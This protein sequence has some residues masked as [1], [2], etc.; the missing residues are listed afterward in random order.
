MFT[1]LEPH[2]G[3][4]LPD[5]QLQYFV[6]SSV[7]MNPSQGKYGGIGAALFTHNYILFHSPHLL[8]SYTQT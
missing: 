6:H 4:R 1:A 7:S 8:R 5:S 3:L 2:V